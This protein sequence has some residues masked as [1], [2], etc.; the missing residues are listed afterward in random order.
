MLAD[1]AQMNDDTQRQQLAGHARKCESQHRRRS[2]I[3]LAK[4]EPGIGIV[5][6]DLDAD[7]WAFNCLNGTLDLRTG[8]LRDH[9]PADL[10]TKRAPVVYKPDAEASRFDKF[11]REI[12]DSD[13]DLIG[14]MQRFFGLCLTG[15]ISEQ[16]LPIC[17]GEGA[18]G[19]STLL[20]T[21][22]AVLGDYACDA[23]P[24]LLTVKRH[25]E[26]PT[27]LADLFGR[28]LVIASETEES[29]RLRVQLVK[30]LTGD[31][32]VKARLMRQDYFEFPRTFKVVMVTN[33]KPVIRETSHA[34]WRRIRLVPFNVIIADEDQDKDLPRKLWAERAGILRWLVRGCLAWQQDGTL[35]SAPEIE[36]ATRQYRDEQDMLGP[37]LEDRCTTG[38]DV[39]VSRSAI[40]TA[41]TEWAKA[42]GERYP[43]DRVG[44]YERIRARGIQEKTT[45]E[46]GKLARGFAGVGLLN[47]TGAIENAGVT[48]VT[49]L[50]GLR[51]K[52]LP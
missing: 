47:P 36:T 14:F 24:D 32:T 18:N 17:Y 39:W 46:A 49:T 45:R 28:R 23:A 15:D 31:R 43:L 27:Q 48:G 5:P 37:F 25:S 52:K 4:S 42:S 50:P 1:A 40:W 11:L 44:F 9:D 38:P 33:N 29:R 6:D 30:R 35:G 8:E 12:F 13:D 7:P 21:V 16:V 34:I 3:D 26:H 2:M 41:Y 22:S 19:K 20:E 51:L 10:I